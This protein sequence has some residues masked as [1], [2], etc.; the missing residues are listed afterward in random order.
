MLQGD[1]FRGIMGLYT[2]VTFEGFRALML[3]LA[4]EAVGDDWGVGFRVYNRVTGIGMMV[5]M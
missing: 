3:K 5:M 4:T 1:S 2:W